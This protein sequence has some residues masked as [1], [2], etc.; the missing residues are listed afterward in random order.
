MKSEKITSTTPNI[1]TS[2]PEAIIK[3]VQSQ[4]PRGSVMLDKTLLPSR[5]KFYSENI[6][7]KKLGALQ[8]KKL[9]TITE[10]NS[11]VVI[12]NM[13]MSSLWGIDYNNILVGDKLWFIFYLRAFTFNDIPFKIRETCP[14]CNTI[15]NY[16]Y[17]LKNL[18]ISYYDKQL[19]EY[20]E[21]DGDKVEVKFPTISTEAAAERIKN[22]PNVLMDIDKELLDYSSYI[23]K[24]NGE[25]YSLMRAYEY[26]TEMSGMAFS[27]FSNEL[28]EYMFLAKPYAKFVCPHCGEEVEFQVPLS[29]TFFMPKI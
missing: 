6:Y 21:V 8:I 11:N 4:P 10:Q 14:H 2:S 17:V 25:K 28:S 20:F 27:K 26:M 5:G 18:D 1:D 16:D 15:T 13:I 23:Y 9:A 29:P 24:V 19:P 3:S 7:V 22:D 12:N